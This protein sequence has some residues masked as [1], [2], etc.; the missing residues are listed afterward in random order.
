MNKNTYNPTPRSAVYFPCSKFEFQY[1][2]QRIKGIADTKF[3]RSCV[4]TFHLK[5]IHGVRDTV[6]TGM[7]KTVVRFDSSPSLQKLETV[8]GRFICYGHGKKPESI[9]DKKKPKQNQYIVAQQTAKRNDNYCA[10]VLPDE[11]PSKNNA[12]HTIACGD[13]GLDFIFQ[14][15]DDQLA[16]GRITI[17]CRFKRVAVDLALSYQED[18]VGDDIDDVSTITPTEAN[19]NEPLVTVEDQFQLQNRVGVIVTKID[20]GIATL[21]VTSNPNNSPPWPGCTITMNHHE[22]DQQYI[23]YLSSSNNI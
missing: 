23:A 13:R 1:L 14:Q 2:Y 3:T 10:L 7:R 16:D 15:I 9:K 5:R 18:F 11:S 20:N 17:I 6:K 12:K 22:L 4:T 19:S 8:L 21:R